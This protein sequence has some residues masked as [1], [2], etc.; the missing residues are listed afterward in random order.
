MT[1]RPT[2]E[3][4]AVESTTVRESIDLAKK[5]ERE[6]RWG[7]ACAIYEQLVRDPHTLADTRLAALRWLG[8]AYLEQGNRGAALDVLELAVTS[9]DICGSPP[10]VAQALN[11]IGIAYQVGGDLDQAAAIYAAARAKAE[12]A[13]DGALIAMIDQN[14]GTVAMIRGDLRGALEAFRLSHLGYQTLGMRNHEAQILNNI[15]LAYMELGELGDAEIAYTEAAR[16]FEE[17][18]DR[19][20]Q[21]DLAVNKVQLYIAGRRF[22]EAL[23]QCHPLMP[24]PDESA[25]WRGEAFRHLGVI[26]RERGDLAAASENLRKAEQHALESSDLLLRADVSEQLA[27]VYWMQKRHRDMLQTLNAAHSLYT[28]LKA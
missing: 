5:A 21:L 20:R 26:A 4:K 3:L 27:E 8:R 13:G 19:A 10:A 6:G 12:V 24:S 14:L 2:I 22:D 17:E 7:D 18:G 9:A 1:N 23:T 25:P 28:Q 11:V 15:A 16:A